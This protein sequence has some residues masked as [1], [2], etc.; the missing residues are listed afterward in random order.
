MPTWKQFADEVMISMGF[1]TDDALRKRDYFIYNATLVYNK[2]RNQQLKKDFKYGDEL[3][4]SS[5]MSTYI[6]D[7]QHVDVDDSV[8]TEFDASFFDLPTPIMNLD[9]NTGLAAIRYLRNDLPANCPPAMART[10]FSLTTLPAVYNIYQ[11]KYQS[12]RSDRPYAALAQERVYL[13]GVP[14]HINKLIAVLYTSA[15]FADIDLD[16]EIDLPP[17][18]LHTMRQ[19]LLDL[20]SWSLQIPQERLRNDGRDF[21]PNQTIA[22]RP[23]I[24]V[25]HPSQSDE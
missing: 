15:D 18:L 16:A 23:A 9:N 20:G 2:L 25:N 6:V 21:E 8:V 24:S 12:P 14:S 19:M 11:S 4:A 5:M 7:V 22:T 1:E 13:F 17:H 3:G 10:P